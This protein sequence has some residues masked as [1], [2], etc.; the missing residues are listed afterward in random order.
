[1]ISKYDD[2]KTKS[3]R[4]MT[5]EEKKRFRELQ[6]QESALRD[7]ASRSICMCVAC[8]KADRDMVYN[9]AYNA[10]YCA[11]CYGLERLVALKRAKTQKKEGSCEERTIKE[12]S[13]TFL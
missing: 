12:H 7:L 6:K 4:Y 1:M 3:V 5:P 9:K 11:E 13:R 8:G 2:G 10:W